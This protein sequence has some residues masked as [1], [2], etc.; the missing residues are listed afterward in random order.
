MNYSQNSTLQP[1]DHQT[2]AL[3]KNLEE[4]N[5][6][7]LRQLHHT[8]EEF[9][10]YV[11]KCQQLGMD[12]NGANTEAAPVG[13][14]VDDD[15]PSLQAEVARLTTL[16]ETQERLH[17]IES[18]NALNAR[19]G[20][21][22]IQ[23]V[24]ASGSLVGLP[25]KLL[26]IW[27]ASMAKQPSAALGGKNF[28][29][30]INTFQ[31]S[32]MES[33]NKLLAAEPAPEM[34]ANAYTALAR[35]QMKN[36]LFS[37][38]AFSARRAYEEEPKP[39]RLKWLAFRLHEAGEI[40]KADACLSL[41]PPEMPFSDSESRQ[42]DQVRFE[43][44]SERLREAMQ[45]TGFDSR[46]QAM[47]S[48]IQ[49]FRWDC[50]R[51]AKL[52]AEREAEIKSIQ[53]AEARLKQEK[54]AL[55]SRLEAAERRA[56]ELDQARENGA[57]LTA[58]RGEEN[59]FL[60]AQLQQVKGE[61]ELYFLQV[62][63]LEK[64][65]TSLEQEH[66]AILAQQ[67][68]SAKLLEERCA[69]IESLKVTCSKIEQEKLALVTQNEKL[70]N[71]AATRLEE[72]EAITQVLNDTKNEKAELIAQTEESASM[73]TDSQAKIDSLLHATGIIEQE[74]TELERS[75]EELTRQRDEQLR[76]AQDRIRQ[77]E[78]LQ[79][80]AQERETAESELATRQEM[81]REEMVRAEAQLD[82]LKEFL[83]RERGL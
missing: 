28:S 56:L 62:Q 75:I 76:L 49:K 26:R 32:G 31:A 2:Q 4:E 80:K 64:T 81:I 52:L 8:Q 57:K 15:V 30:I 79:R 25:T 29:K 41:L 51:Q 46:R 48:Q 5:D 37:E 35:Y 22:L 65:R 82:L 74:R 45:K 17:E 39:F 44:K 70:A 83:L 63:E 69:E 20:D 38:A 10:R 73:M 43:A 27:R 1:A 59:E 3:F 71:L 40:A 11:L 61:L 13:D 54:S 77:I 67:E 60:L 55:T 9:E 72:I 24:S 33:V 47:E 34:R 19:L 42:R 14:W 50:H 12:G 36:G 23:S 7:L 58:A 16:V 21:I 53:Q 78:E 18:K 66:D 6:L 68:A